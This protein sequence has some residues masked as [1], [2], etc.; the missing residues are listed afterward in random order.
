MDNGVGNTTPQVCDRGQWFFNTS[1][2]H[3]YQRNHFWQ[4]VS[5]EVLSIF[6][7][8]N[9]MQSN[10]MKNNVKEAERNEISHN[11]HKRVCYETPNAYAKDFYFLWRG[12]LVCVT[13]EQWTWQESLEY[14]YHDFCTIQYLRFVCNKNN[15]PS[16]YS[17]FCT[18]YIH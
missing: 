16:L 2:M 14:E 12:H 9:T 13:A 8:S 17:W 1:K 4:Y 18:K 7:L 15:I 10:F 3:F 11:R 5:V 6:F